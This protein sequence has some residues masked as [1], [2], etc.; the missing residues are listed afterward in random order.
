MPLLVPISAQLIFLR[1]FECGIQD[2]MR[3]TVVCIPVSATLVSANL[4]F[5]ASPPRLDGKGS[6]TC[7]SLI[8]PVD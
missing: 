7:R 2:E 4:I 8:C 5:E 3:G 1:G 6:T